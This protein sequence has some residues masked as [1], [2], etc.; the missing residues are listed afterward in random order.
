M[1]A[2]DNDIRE[3][4]PLAASLSYV[5]R[6]LP[7][8]QDAAIGILEDGRTTFAFA[9]TPPPRDL[10]ELSARLVSRLRPD[11]RVV[12]HFY[13][14]TGEPNGD[15]PRLI[16]RYGVD[17][18]LTWG[19]AAIETFA[20]FNDWG[21]YD[22][23]RDFNNTFP[24]QVMADLSYSLGMPRWFGYP[25][26]RIGVRGHWRSLDEYSPRYEPAETGDLTGSEPDGDEY[27]IR[28][29]LHMTL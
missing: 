11:A 22:Y 23:H 19:Q 6:H 21:P 24:I 17:C 14:G 8:T 7:T 16:H 20:K 5:Y 28:T 25:Q 29:Y 2:W 3:D 18:R 27:E 4:A 12:A 1:W 9:S 15:S 26:T 10:W 13:A